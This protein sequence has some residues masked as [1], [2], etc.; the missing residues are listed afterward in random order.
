MINF[1][2]LGS[3]EL[4]APL[5]MQLV[6]A[7]VVEAGAD[8]SLILIGATN[9][10]ARALLETLSVERRRRCILVGVY[11][12]PEPQPAPGS[13]VDLLE[14]LHALGAVHI[15]DGEPTTTEFV[16]AMGETLNLPSLVG[17]RYLS[18]HTSDNYGLWH[19]IPQQTA[20]EFFVRLMATLEQE[21]RWLEAGPAIRYIA[22]R[23]NPCKQDL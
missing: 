22:R 5:H 9:V 21:K 15:E 18:E 20:G 7:G 2:A 11:E 1:H 12:R 19:A 3:A 16:G 23:S 6:A 13:P 17:A 14:R 8:A 10:D 4:L